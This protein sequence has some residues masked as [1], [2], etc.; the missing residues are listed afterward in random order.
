[1]SKVSC[2]DK[3]VGGLNVFLAVF[4]ILVTPLLALLLMFIAVPFVVVG[5][6]IK[7]AGEL[8]TEFLKEVIQFT[9]YFWGIANKGVC[10]FKFGKTKNQKET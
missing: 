3:F 9:T 8:Q 1:M 4:L 10:R 6:A 2:W 5:A 7:A